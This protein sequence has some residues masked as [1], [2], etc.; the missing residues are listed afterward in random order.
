MKTILIATDFSSAA[1]NASIYA[2]ALAKVLNAKIILCNAY[3]IPAASASL[4]V[5]V[6]R[7]DIMVQTNQRLLDEA[8]FLDPEKK[9]IEI[10][11]DEGFT[12]DVIIN[13]ANEKKLILLFAV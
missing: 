7:Y 10:S 1:R 11:C 3:K 9:M 6:S 2:V 12:E 4:N 5:S 8:D 13:T